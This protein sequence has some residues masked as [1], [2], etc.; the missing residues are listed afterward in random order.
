MP[1]A[2][3][4][5]RAAHRSGDP[6]A[7]LFDRHRLSDVRAGS[8]LLFRQNE[9]IAQQTVRLDE[10]NR[11]IGE[12]TLRID[13]QTRLLIA[14]TEPYPTL[15]GGT[16]FSQAVI[17]ASPFERTRAGFACFDGALVHKTSFRGALLAGATFRGAVLLDNDFT[18]ADLRSVDFDGAI[19]FGADWLERLAAGAAPDTFRA[20]RYR[21]D[22]VAEPEVR[23]IDIVYRHLGVEVPDAALAG[24]TAFRVVRIKPFE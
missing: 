4:G 18:G 21:L 23:R 24:K 3:R 13:G 11:L 16:D 5:G 9:L 1:G 17:V 2:G 12:Q 8:A 20:D 15:T 14:Q 10:Q 6:G 19:V 22:P 7:V